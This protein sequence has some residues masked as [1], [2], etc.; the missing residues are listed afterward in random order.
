LIVWGIRKATVNRAK[1]Q[2]ALEKR[3]EAVKAKVAVEIAK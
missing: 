1:Q 3:V 2:A